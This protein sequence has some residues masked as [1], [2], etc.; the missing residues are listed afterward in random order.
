MIDVH[1]RNRILIQ[2]RNKTEKD[3]QKDVQAHDFMVQQ[4]FLFSMSQ[5]IPPLQ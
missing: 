4:A 5:P 3:K 1:T 2:V